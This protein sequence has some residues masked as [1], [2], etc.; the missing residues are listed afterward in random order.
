MNSTAVRSRTIRRSFRR[1]RV[2]C[3]SSWRLVTMSSSPPI[4]T[5]RLPPRRSDESWSSATCTSRSQALGTIHPLHRMLGSL[6]G[7]HARGRRDLSPR[8][9]SARVAQ[10]VAARARPGRHARC[11]ETVLTHVF[12]WLGRPAHGEEAHV[13]PGSTA[14]VIVIPIVIV[15]TLF[16]WRSTPASCASRP[17]DAYGV[18][19]TCLSLLT[20]GSRGPSGRVR[21]DPW[22][23]TSWPSFS[24]SPLRP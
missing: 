7:R 11:T 1:A 19:R 20:W 6:C 17:A 24:H 21:E 2:R 12:R 9:W 4:A 14:A 5:I 18:C 23:P 10:A 15:V 8:R 13:M 22:Q 16:A 3:S